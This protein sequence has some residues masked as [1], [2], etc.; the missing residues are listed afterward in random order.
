[1]QGNLSSMNHYT[2]YNTPLIETTL[3]DNELSPCFVDNSMVLV[4]SNSPAQRHKKLKDMM[5]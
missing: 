1:M 2:F 3:S 5:E 4:I